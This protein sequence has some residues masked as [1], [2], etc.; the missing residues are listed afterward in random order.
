MYCGPDGPERLSLDTERLI[1][2]LFDAV[3]PDV[4]VRRDDAV[5]NSECDFIWHADVLAVVLFLQRV[6]FNVIA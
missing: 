5:V 2:R 1:V 4:V 3:L 6:P